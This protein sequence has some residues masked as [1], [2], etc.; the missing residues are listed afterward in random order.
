M[1][2]YPY[3][4]LV[5]LFHS[6]MKEPLSKIWQYS[7]LDQ[8]LRK[9]Y[10]IIAAMMTSF[11]L[12]SL[13][14]T[15]SES[16]RRRISVGA[17]NCLEFHVH[18]PLPSASI[19]EMTFKRMHTTVFGVGNL[20]KYDFSSKCWHC[21]YNCDIHNSKRLWKRWQYRLRWRWRPPPSS[22]PTDFK[23]APLG[24]GYLSN[25]NFD[26]GYFCKFTNFH[27]YLSKFSIIEQ[28]MWRTIFT[29]FSRCYPLN[30]GVAVAYLRSYLIYSV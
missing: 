22:W 16:P 1:L 29:F 17:G 24:L 18:M 14:I 3:T 4:T 28:R 20:H 30:R 27:G 13:A 5:H 7:N 11:Q 6:T 2:K 25:F 26:Q 10:R 19:A 21:R 8:N 12:K 23:A 9:R 15:R